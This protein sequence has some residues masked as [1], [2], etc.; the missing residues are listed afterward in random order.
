M[1]LRVQAFDEAVAKRIERIP[2]DFVAPFAW[3]G[4]F[5]SP[6][7]WMAFL[8]A[9]Q[10][11]VI[12]PGALPL[13]AVAVIVSIP[14]ATVIKFFFRRKRP[15]TVFVA[16]MR[17]K[18]YSFPSSHA[19]SAVVASGYLAYVTWSLS[20]VVSIACVTLAGIIGISRIRIGAHYPTDVTAG[21]VLGVVVLSILLSTLGR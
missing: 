14:L 21:W 7:L 13:V 3:L 11:L 6:P 10:A 15:V 1:R 19:Y 18:S 20:A 4:R 2:D 5:T 9:L 16:S 8:V 12:T 17:I